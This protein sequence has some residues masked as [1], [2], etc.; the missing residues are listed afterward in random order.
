MSSRLR[1]YGEKN[2]DELTYEK[3]KLEAVLMSIA[4]GV[5]VCDSSDNVILL[6][7]TGSD[8]LNVDITEFIGTDINTYCDTAGNLI[9]SEYIK[10]F[11]DMPLNQLQKEPL[12]FQTE[13]DKKVV[14]ALVSPIFTSN[15]EY[16]GYI[17][18]L[19]DITKEAE[20]D[21]LKSNFISNVSHELRTPVT[22][23]R[24]Y[25]DTLCNYI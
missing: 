6:N 10:Q 18:V 7:N 21:K 14:K 11:K 13:I 17:V 12:A 15:Q 2:I 1:E 4:N 19:H 9:F 23:L 20:T 8:M 22:V 3:N 24:S 16:L 5:I 25:I